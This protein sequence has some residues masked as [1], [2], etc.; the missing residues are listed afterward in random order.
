[1]VL[2]A[3][4]F[5]QFAFFAPFISGIAAETIYLYW[6]LSKEPINVFSNA[7]TK[8]MILI[9]GT[10]PPPTTIANIVDTIRITATNNFDE[11]ASLHAHG[12]LK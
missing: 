9:N 11:P 8:T 3:I 2:Y 10:R 6:E 5:L 12:F 1:L 4:M 7:G